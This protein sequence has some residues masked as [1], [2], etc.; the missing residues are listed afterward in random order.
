MKLDASIAP[1]GLNFSLSGQ[2][3][4]C[5]AGNAV[6]VFKYDK[7]NNTVYFSVRLDPALPD[8]FVP[9]ATAIDFSLLK[10]GNTSFRLNGKFNTTLNVPASRPV[11]V[12]IM[13]SLNSVGNTS[14]LKVGQV[15]ALGKVAGRVT[16]LWLL[17]WLLAAFLA[18]FLKVFLT[19]FLAVFLVVFLAV[20]LVAATRYPHI[21]HSSFPCSHLL[22]VH[23]H[24]LTAG[25]P[26]QSPS[27]AS[28]ASPSG[29]WTS[30]P[31]S[32]SR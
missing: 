23:L 5:G 4:M 3:N 22:P 12:I 13:A 31:P 32:T 11:G 15:N 17:A 16:G 19:V 18:I 2:V 9:G 20:S 7:A 26:R 28:P 29:Q 24:S 8:P 25:P 6:G 21:S 14:I 1:G 10:V 27:P 30:T